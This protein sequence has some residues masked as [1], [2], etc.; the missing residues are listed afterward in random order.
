MNNI[1][2][3]TL[4]MGMMSTLSHASIYTGVNLGI[5]AVT[6]DK[7]LTYPLDDITPARAHF[8]SAYT[9]F[10]AQVLAGYELPIRPQWSAAL[11]VDADFFTGNA[12]YTVNNWYFEEGINAQ[13]KLDYGFSLFLL[14]AYHYTDKV[15][16]F[17]GPGVSTSSFIIHAKNTAGNVG[18]SENY[19]QWLTGGGL[20]IGLATQIM[21]A[22]DVLLTYQFTQYESMSRTH[23]EPLSEESLRGS[24]RPYT[25]LVLLGVKWHPA[26]PITYDK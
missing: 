23:I 6:V 11:E 24:Y 20:K 15:T 4:L 5:N 16:F 18:V 2:A 1:A 22:I 12:Q 21:P 13:E 3:V 26:N 8:N 14:P 9:N 10:H 25:N 17:A 19:S 7:K